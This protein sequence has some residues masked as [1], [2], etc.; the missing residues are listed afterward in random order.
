MPS[1]GQSRLPA[2][3][4]FFGVNLDKTAALSLKALAEARGVTPSLVMREIIAGAIDP[5]AAADL[6]DL[7]APYV[8]GRLE[9]PRQFFGVILDSGLAA[10]LC[11]LASE[12]RTSQSEIVRL[13]LASALETPQQESQQVS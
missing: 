11:A 3:K 5:A 7:P 10:A 13:A 1:P 2:G 6:V 9:T 4:R 8:K 12:K